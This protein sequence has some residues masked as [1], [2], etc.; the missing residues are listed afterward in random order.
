MIVVSFT[1][2]LDYSFVKYGCKLQFC[3]SCGMTWFAHNMTAHILTFLQ[4]L[5]AS[6]PGQPG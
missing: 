1:R 6:F 3:P 5:P 4:H 2:I